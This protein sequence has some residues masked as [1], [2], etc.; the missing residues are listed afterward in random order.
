VVILWIEKKTPIK[1]TPQE[2][3][4]KW[5]SQREDTKRR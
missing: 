4:P 5:L 1:T 3:T 2:E